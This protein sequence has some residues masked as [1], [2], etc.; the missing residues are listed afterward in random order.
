MEAMI[1]VPC[2]IGAF[3][4]RNTPVLPGEKNCFSN[5]KTSMIWFGDRI[6]KNIMGVLTILKKTTNKK[7]SPFKIQVSI[8]YSI[9]SKVS[10]ERNIW[11]VERDI[12][13][14]LKKLCEQ[15]GVE[16]LEAETCIDHIHMLVSIPSQISISQFMGYL[17]GK[18][19]LMIFD[20]HAN[21]KYKYGSRHFWCSGH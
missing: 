10:A 2:L 5:R 9:R 7:Y 3:R 19:S 4:C 6:T 8:S 17:K 21:L 18:R 16:I 15:K 11:Q 20:R 14:I 12:G 13:K 1:S